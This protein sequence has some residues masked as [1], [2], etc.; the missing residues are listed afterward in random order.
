MH[1]TMWYVYLHVPV[2]VCIQCSGCMHA[3]VWTT[4]CVVCVF[5]DNEMLYT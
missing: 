4:M 2:H 1:I 3:C 5:S